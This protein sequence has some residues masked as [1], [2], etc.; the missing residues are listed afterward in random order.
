MKKLVTLF[1]QNRAEIKAYVFDSIKGV[2]HSK[3]SLDYFFP[4]FDSLESVYVVDLNCM[5][6]SP[7]FQKNDQVNNSREDKIVESLKEH[8][9]L[10]ENG[11]YVSSI[12]LSSHDGNPTVTLSKKLNDN[13]IIT[14]NFNVVKLLEEMKVISSADRFS[15][16]SKF[17]YAGI[18]YSLTLF[19][20]ILVIY[21]LGSFVYYGLMGDVSIFKS[22]FKSIIALT[23]GLAVFD[24]AKNL[25]E[26]E[27]IF[28]EKFSEAHGS[29]KLLEKFLISIIIA[30]SIESLMT[31][32][33]I[34]LHDYKDM[35][36]AVYLIVATSIMVVALGYFNKSTK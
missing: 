22:I 33:K 18:G 13:E 19:A 27:V 6:L 29:K 34:A 16:L 4:K 2:E 31:V 28:K 32:F 11:E 24:L 25:L 7:L 15:K 36:H 9:V 26:H 1:K 23:L 12:Y 5:Q 35:M 21:S 8:M 10:D 17:V 3:G 30:L 14:F 20:I